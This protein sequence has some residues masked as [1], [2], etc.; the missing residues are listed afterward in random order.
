MNVKTIKQEADQP[1]T[2]FRR[3][4][5]PHPREASDFLK[6]IVC[7]GLVVLKNL[8]SAEGIKIIHGSS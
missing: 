7:Q 2:V 6:K 3:P 1:P 5:H 8:L 4:K